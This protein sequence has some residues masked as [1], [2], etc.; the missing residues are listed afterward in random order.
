MNRKVLIGVA[1]VSILLGAGLAVRTVNGN[2]RTAQPAAPT[3]AQSRPAAEKPAAHQVAQRAV[4]QP[5]STISVSSPA[6]ENIV[7]ETGGPAQQVVRIKPDRVLAT[8]NGVSITLKD[9]IPLPK[10]KAGAEQMLSAEMYEFLFKRAVDREVT[11]QAARTQSVDLNDSQKQRLA[12]IRGDSE[13]RDP[14]V[15]DNLHQSPE[16]TDFEQRD[17]TGVAL[18]SV[19]AE[20]A[21]VASPYVTSEQV[22]AYFQDHKSDYPQVSTDPALRSAESWL[23]ADTDIRS[24]L[25]PLLQAEHDRQMAQFMAELKAKASVVVVAQQQ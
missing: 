14:A 17:F 12:Q 15:F 8:V 5:S 2:R 18:Q 21:G 13:R 6:R 25:T 4:G 19:L 10:E 20:K 22:E 16:N 11:F 9:L 23:A 3:P 7:P 24:K 1:A